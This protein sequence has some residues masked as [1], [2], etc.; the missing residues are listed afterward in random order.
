VRNRTVA[1]NLASST[2]PAG[3]ELLEIEIDLIDQ[4]LARRTSTGEQRAVA[5]EPQ[6][7]VDFYGRVMAM[8]TNLD[9]AVSIDT[10]PGETLIRPAFGRCC[11]CRL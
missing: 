11:P 7:V 10:V 3:T 1:K 5:L 2:I 4:R 9:I 6:T 8:L